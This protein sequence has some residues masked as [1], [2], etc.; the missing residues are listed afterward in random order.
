VTI[1]GLIAYVEDRVGQREL[2]NIESEELESMMNAARTRAAR[3]AYK[4]DHRSLTENIYNLVLGAADAQGVQQAPFTAQTDLLP[5]SIPVCNDIQHAT[6]NA[7]AGA[8]LAFE[9]LAKVSD[10][11]AIRSRS[12]LAYAAVGAQAIHTRF[13]SGVLTNG[14]SLLVRACKIPTLAAWPTQIEDRLT[15]AMVELIQERMGREKT[16]EVTAGV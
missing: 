4:A 2:T 3:E 12:L 5:E 15:D 11:R 1:T 8:G 9:I 16:E 10:L 13:P 14:S 6:V 7:V